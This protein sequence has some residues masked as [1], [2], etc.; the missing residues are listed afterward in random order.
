MSTEDASRL[1][2]ALGFATVGDDE[3]VFT[4]GDA[5]ALRQAGF[6][7]EQLIADPELR[8]AITRLLGRTFSRLASWQGQL[9]VELVTTQPELLRSEDA[10]IEF[11]ERVVPVMQDIQTFVWRRQLASYLS[12]VASHAA[13]EVSVPGV[14]P[15]VV[16]FADMAGF[17]TLTRKASEAE[18]RAL[19]E[20]FESV[21]NEVIGALGG[22]I[23]KTIGDEVLFVADAPGAG[24]DIALTLQEAARADGRLPPVRIGMAAGPVVS[25]LGD[26]YGSTVNIA[27]RLTSICRPSW[28]LVDRV[29]AESLR[30]DD[31]FSLK[32]RRPE[33]VRGYHHLRQW[34]LRRSVHVRG[35]HDSG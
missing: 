15:L 16:G 10:V 24:A 28:V 30:D 25:R 3:A 33:S 12:R 9:L 13:A 11:V 23:V 34:R 21:T 14:A 4:E 27:S 7:T 5:T 1:W 26:V 19:L 29:M 31:R 35:E 6:L 20:A 22:R 17:T 32:T 2:R 8:L 18:L